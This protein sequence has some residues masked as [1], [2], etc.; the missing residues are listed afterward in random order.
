MH[1]T[2]TFT[3]I[4][5]VQS[6]EEDE[7]QT[8]KHLRD[9]L[10][11]LNGELGQSVPIE[12]WT[13]ESVVCFRAIVNEL[14]EEANVGQIPLLHVECHGDEHA[15][16]IFENASELSWHDLA[17]MLGRLNDACQY[18]LFAVF[19]ACFGA[20][21]LGQINPFTTSPCFASVAPTEHVYPDEIE[22]GFKQFYRNLFDGWDAALA[23]SRLRNR[24]LTRGRW[25]AE[26]AE[27][28]F[29]RVVMERC[30]RTVMKPRVRALYRHLL[31]KGNRQSIGKL[32]RWI[33]NRNKQ[34][35]LDEYFD[36]FFGTRKFPDNRQRF[37]GVH[38][39]MKK[40]LSDIWCQ[41]EYRP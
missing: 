5:I 22:V 41:R 28:W 18:N 40:R 12:L 27:R 38:Q 31:E 4:V 11:A 20:H 7:R 15:G 36:R 14:T 25:F 21:F 39:R 33:R 32:K 1:S 3:K 13:C 29:E 24:R 37:S 9:A 16:L 35:F 2:S 6:L 8:G 23:V 30:T 34:A 26:T 19:A 17:A 10:V